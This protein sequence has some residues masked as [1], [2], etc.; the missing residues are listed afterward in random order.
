MFEIISI[1]IV[2]GVGYLIWDDIGPEAIAPFVAITAAFLFLFGLIIV[3][4]FNLQYETGRQNSKT[5]IYSLKSGIQIK[6]EFFMFGGIINGTEYYYMYQS[7]D[8]GGFTRLNLPVSNCEIY[9]DEDNKPYIFQQKVEYTVS[10]WIAIWPEFKDYK[11][12]T[13]EI[14]VPK[15]TII[16]QYKLD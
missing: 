3:E 16:Q 15:N 11:D 9:Q 6:G 14:H 13:I 12:S 8:K 1:L 7:N 10:K 4:V 5:E 2:I